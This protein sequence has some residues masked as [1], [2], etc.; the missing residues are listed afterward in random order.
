MDWLEV[1]WLE[2]DLLEMDWLDV[3]L[4]EVEIRVENLRVTPDLPEVAPRLPGLPELRGL[5]MVKNTHKSGSL[6]FYS[7][8]LSL[9]SLS[10]HFR[11]TWRTSGCK[12]T[13]GWRRSGWRTSGSHPTFLK[14]RLASLKS[15]LSSLN[16]ALL[17]WIWILYI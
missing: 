9:I 11:L 5:K 17:I 3:D 10:P 6:S 14:S 7:L 4:L 8:F 2:V 15:C 12:R 1:D 16:S 13:S